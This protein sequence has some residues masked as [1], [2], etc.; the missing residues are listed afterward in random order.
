MKQLLIAEKPSL[1]KSVM[2]AVQSEHFVKKDGYFEGR[3]YIISYAFGHLFSLKALEGYLQASD[4]NKGWSLKML[5]F[6]PGNGKAEDYQFELLRSKGGK[7]KTAD[8]SIA[9]QFKVLQKLMNRDDVAGI[10]HC[11]DADREGELIIRLIL[12]KGLKTPKPVRRLWLSDQTEET[13]RYQ[14]KHMK[15]D[16]AYDNL[17]NEGLCR[18]IMDWMYGINLSRYVTLSSPDREVYAIGRVLTP[19]VQAIGVRD[20][21]IRDF[22]PEKYYQAESV[23]EMNGSRITLTSDQ[24]FDKDHLTDAQALADRLNG[25]KA[26]VTN[27]EEKE[28]VRKRPKL[29]S[30][31][32]LQSY[33]AKEYKM[34]ME[35]SLQLTQS[36]YEKGLVT[37]PRTNTQYLAE[38]EK[39]RVKKIIAW[40]EKEAKV[41]ICFRDG[42][43]IFD[44][45]KIESHSALTPTGKSPEVLSDEE[46]IVYTAIKNRFFAVF[47]AEDCIVHEVK[48]GV[49]CGEQKFSLTGEHLVKNGFFEFCPGQIKNELPAFS[50]G[51]EL[52][53]HFTAKEKMTQPPKHYTT[54]TLTYFLKH[55]F[56]GQ[57]EDAYEND[58]PLY[59][60]IRQGTE[61]GTEATR[62]A[63]ITK[64]IS[65]KYIEQKNDSYR[66]LPKGE[67]MM[68]L[69]EILH[70][71]ISANTSIR[72]QIF[73]RKVYDGSWTI[74]DTL[75]FAMEQIREFIPAGT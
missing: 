73:L 32:D 12:A 11:G 63:I 34:P 22:I 5:P 46:R 56:R 18:T 38:K 41:P 69:L 37:Y 4:Q 61:L 14:L 43:E 65:M 52:P 55:P 30:L 68:E 7:G 70:I 40:L 8:P 66:I 54:K 23:C 75:S 45:K 25:Q 15:K 26:V 17:Y 36:L 62:T 31:S 1:A 24:R 13:I 6:F 29:F 48:Y 49:I 27:V 64:A 58:D 33:L 35:K 16:E 59:N 28:I 44:D 67:K 39:D 9:R 57:D 3:W 72:M 20:Q 19:I 51:D 74:D 50:V 47:C 60:D 71:G 21:E 10:I 53:H 42:K 2:A